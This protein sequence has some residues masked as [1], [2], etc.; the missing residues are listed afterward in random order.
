MEKFPCASRIRS[1]SQGHHTWTDEEIT[2]FRSTHKAGSNARTLMEIM[3]GTGLRISDAA[4]LGR[5]HIRDGLVTMRTKKTGVTVTIPLMPDL[6]AAHGA[7]P[8]GQMHFVQT[9]AGQAFS[10]KSAGQWFRARC[11]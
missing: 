6:G 8:H 2:L 3:L 4:I 5:Q 9:Q 1:G 10:I 11:D 7:V